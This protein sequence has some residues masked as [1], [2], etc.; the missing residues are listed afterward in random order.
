MFPILNT[1]DKEKREKE[2]QTE[3]ILKVKIFIIFSFLGLTVFKAQ[4][5]ATFYS[6]DSEIFHYS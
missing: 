6:M 5:P 1:I 3:R 4:I 2:R